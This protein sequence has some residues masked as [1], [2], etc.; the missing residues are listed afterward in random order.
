[1]GAITRQ[2]WKAAVPVLAMAMQAPAPDPFQ[3]PFRH[4]V[5]DDNVTKGGDFHG[6]CKGAGD[7]DGDGYPDIVFAGSELAWYRYPNWSKTVIA[8][9][10]QE[11]S[12][13][14]Q[15][16]DMDGDGDPDIV[17]PDGKQGKIWWFENPRPK[18][19]AGKPEQWKRHLVGM[20]GSFAHDVEV[21]DVDGDGKMDVLTRKKQ[22]LLWLQR[23]PD[24]FDRVEIK[25]ALEGGEG[26]ALADINGDGRLD[27][28]Q[29]GYWMEC[30]KDPVNGEW[31]RHEFAA[32]WG[33][34]IAVTVADLDQDQA[35]D[36]V[37]GPAESAGKLVW[38]EHPEDPINGK[39]TEHLI[40]DD[41]SHLHTFKVADIN[42]DGVQEVVAAEMQQ[43][44]SKRV[45]VYF[46]QKGKWKQEVIATT[47]S[48][49]LRL[50]DIGADGDIDIIGANWGGPHHPLE[51]WENRLIE[52]PAL[53]P[54]WR[55]QLI[56]SKRARWGDF[57]KPFWN[58]YL[59]LAFG[60]VTGD[61]RKDIVSGRYFYRNPGRDGAPWARVDFGRNVDAVLMVD[62]DGDGRAEVIAEALPDVYWM[63]P[64]DRQ[65]NAWDAVKIGTVPATQHVNSQG[66]ALAQIVRGGKPEVLL[67]G[68]DGLYMFEIPA[69]PG[70]GAWKRTRIGAGT[71]EEGIAP[72]DFDG[73]GKID[74]ASSDKD[75]HQ[76]FWLRNPGDGSE[77]WQRI[78]IGK[79]E[80]WADRFASADINGDGRPDVIVTEECAYWG[81][82]VYWFENPGK[83][84]GE[85]K[86]HT[87][88]QQFSS[89]AMDVY[90]M[91]G[92]GAMDIVVNEH[93]GSRKL[94]WWE[95][96]EHGSRWV[97]HVIDTG[98]EGHL[99]AR[100]VDLDGDGRLAIVDIAW[101]TWPNMHMWRQVRPHKT[102]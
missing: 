74:V 39:W 46:K 80:R 9:A 26:S 8:R 73:D 72:A 42:N 82:S 87:V 58:R 48:H 63:K 47:G 43:S 102:K 33:R 51:M 3:V 11:F 21:G 40:D 81:A 57:A 44:K 86:R 91:N 22:T 61:R 29:N 15:V 27:I 55:Y 76:V 5:I 68:G 71:S 78:P 85:W 12:T 37:M 38:Y 56:D 98:K 92:D 67:S 69:K 79:T 36:I 65:G 16:A 2:W 31:L 66:Y 4:I 23:G 18:G 32:G 89:N 17:V 64:R 28:V 35:P 24:K 19:D 10:E 100:V 41:V 97:E 95:N 54:G 50:A 101:D 1:M 99:G 34:Q 88:V 90:D 93:R 45:V 75:G 52:R 53:E 70:A 30:P 7:I 77:D 14:M 62:A 83:A 94:A 20:Q 84:G 59:G 6:D 96:Q 60:D 49:N 13:D 25:G